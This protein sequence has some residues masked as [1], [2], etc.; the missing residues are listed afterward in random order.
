MT[1]Q[2]PKS[3]GTKLAPLLGGGFFR[4]L[5]RPTA[6]VYIDCAERL[7]EAADEGGQ[8]PH[9]EARMLIREVLVQ[10]PNIQLDEDEGGQF[11]DLNLRA[12][13]FFKKLL[14][15]HW[16]QPRR[17]SLDENYVLI[18]PPLRRL[19]RMLRELGEDRPAELRDF[20]ST[21]RALCKDMLAEGAL[22][23]KKLDPEEMRQ[24]VKDLLERA[25]R[26][27]D[28][29]HGV[30]T[31]I[32]QHEFAQRESQTAQETLHRFL[33]DFHAGE[34]MMCY[35]ALQEGGLLPRLNQARTV[36]QEA[37]Y[38][39]FTKQR[40]A[41]GLAK[42]FDLDDATAYTEAERLLVKLEKQLATIP[43]K[44]RIIDGRMADFSRF[45]DA[46]Y[47]YQT[48]MRGRRPEQIKAYMDRAA[49]IHAGQSFSNLANEPGMPLLS[50]V[51]ELYFGL[52]SLSRPRRQ[53][54]SVDLSIEATPDAADNEAA[55]EEIRRRNLYSLTPQRAAR[56]IESH[57]A[58]K[59]TRV[60][61]ED[62]SVM[63]ED[64]LLDLM[65]VLAFDRGPAGTSR[66]SIRW[67]VHPM[68]ADFGTEPE[69]IVCDAKAGRLL[70]R[71]TLERI[72]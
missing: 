72:S 11:R 9:E 45:S 61:T 57:L 29:M 24:T 5:S 68:R 26:A 64:D 63:T 27:D 21:L 16:I 12:A 34:H 62:L 17:V 56:F 50:P 36:A 15:V 48:E 25:G 30:E 28:Q 42:H 38:D 44:Q 40:L 49:H 19:L 52:D 22:D 33:V 8:L 13:Q 58:E 20:A 7:V 59:G 6:A 66:R 39:P 37:L 65:A 47:R 32:L 55:K 23:P 14:E 10:H 31:L 53:R 51:V 4:P 46:R 3:L 71:F 60:S 41:E 54:P 67:R 2:E 69:R 70:E 18:S 35:D 1:N 43:V